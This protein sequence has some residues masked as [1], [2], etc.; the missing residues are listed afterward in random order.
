MKQN[1]TTETVRTC[2]N[3]RLALSVCL[4][5]SAAPLRPCTF[6]T[7]FNEIL[8]SSLPAQSPNTLFQF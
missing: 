4:R 8:Q 5:D 7:Q 3:L 1:Q 6:G 2:A